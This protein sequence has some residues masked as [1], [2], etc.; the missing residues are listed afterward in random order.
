MSNLSTALFRTDLRVENDLASL[1]F[2]GL[3]KGRFR[4]SRRLTGPQR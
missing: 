3:F 4:F 2:T 1:L